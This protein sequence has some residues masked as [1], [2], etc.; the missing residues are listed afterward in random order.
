MANFFPS[1][2]F[3]KTIKFII[4]PII[5]DIKPIHASE[6]RLKINVTANINETKKPIIANPL[7]IS[8]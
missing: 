8:N 4:N 1:N 2:L 6:D 7:P 3:T 5:V